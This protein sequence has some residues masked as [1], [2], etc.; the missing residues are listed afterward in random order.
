MF[1]EFVSFVERERRKREK[2]EIEVSSTL[3]LH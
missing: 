3:G 1:A 2:G